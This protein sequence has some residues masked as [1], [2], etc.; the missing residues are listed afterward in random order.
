MLITPG[1]GRQW[2]LQV[3]FLREV[4][5]VGGMYGFE[6]AMES[7][8]RRWADYW[9]SGAAIDLGGAT[10]PR[11]GELERRIVLS[12]IHAIH[13]AGSTAAETGLF[14]NS[15]YGKFHLEL[16]WWHSVLFAAWG[17]WAAFE[18]SMGVYARF[19]ESSKARAKQQGFAG[20]RWPKRY[21]G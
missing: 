17:R 7:S 20:A 10:D 5:P 6:E 13:C 8:G 1:G 19:L 3:E 11:A 4:T 2:A 9:Q 21:G 15:W 18:K 14:C 12:H 16:H